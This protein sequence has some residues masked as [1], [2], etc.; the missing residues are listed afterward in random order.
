V[1]VKNISATL[2]GSTWHGSLRLP[3]QCAVPGTCPIRFDLHADTLATEDLGALLSARP[4]GQPWYRFLAS[5]PQPSVPYLRAL[6]ASGKL[7]VSRVTI[8]KL[9]AS[10]VSANVELENG[11]LRLSDLQGDVFGGRHDG[12]WT[13]DFTSKPPSYSGSGKFAKVALPQLADAMHDNWI[14]GSADGSYRATATGWTMPDLLASATAILEVGAY[15]GT[16]P[17][18]TLASGGGVLLLRRFDGRWLV[19][20]GKLEIQEGK[21]DSSSGIYQVSGTAS[22]GRVLD[23]KLKRN[24][25]PSFDITGTVTQP[26]VEQAT[27][28]ETQAALKP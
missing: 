22:F 4:S 21:L 8:H 23:L 18:I 19:R 7:S 9:V 1:E 26:H 17:H 24:G 2:A 16:L 12:E 3:R 10:R 25:A 28:A 6:R 5:A 15:D 14:T 27:S 13:A 11:L 20:N